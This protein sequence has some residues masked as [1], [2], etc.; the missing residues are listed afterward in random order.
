MHS[1]V[2]ISQLIFLRFTCEELQTLAR[3]LQLPAPLITKCGYH[4]TP[5]EALG[6][7]CAWLRSP[8]DQW[9]LS[10]KY[11]CPQSA[12]SEI[13]NETADYI[14]TRWEHLLHWDDTGVLSPANL[15]KYAN[16]LQDLGHRHSQSL[17][18]SIVQFDKCAIQEILKN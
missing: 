4:A 16:A 13:T 17:G 6:L 1:S 2:V 8:E 14:N 18:F 10:T 15:Q 12:I 9:S 3:V 5:L 11:R 7:L